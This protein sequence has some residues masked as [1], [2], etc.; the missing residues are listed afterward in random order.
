MRE[1]HARLALADEGGEGDHG[2]GDSRAGGILDVDDLV[3]ADIIGELV[4]AIAVSCILQD[5]R[6]VLNVRDAINDGRSWPPLVACCF[7]RVQVDCGD[8]LQ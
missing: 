5:V 6:D 2:E 4:D 1:V 3:V 8:G 7:D